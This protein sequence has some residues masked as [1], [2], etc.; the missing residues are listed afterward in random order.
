MRP[1]APRLVRILRRSQ[2][3]GTPAARRVVPE[4][5]NQHAG[6]LPALNDILN[7]RRVQAGAQYPSNIRIEPAITSRTFRNIPIHTRETLKKLIKER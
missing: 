5:L 2:I 4:P 3:Q 1:S 6:R 7:Q